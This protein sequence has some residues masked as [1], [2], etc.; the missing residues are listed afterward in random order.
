[1]QI[2][3]L[4]FFKTLHKYL[5]YANPVLFYFI[6]VIPWIFFPQNL[7]KTNCSNEMKYSKNCI[8]Q[9]FG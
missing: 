6:T 9:I 2:S 8:S 4:Q 5:V 3:L 1:M 7:D